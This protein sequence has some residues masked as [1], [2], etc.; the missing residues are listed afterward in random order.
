MGV[1]STGFGPA[2]VAIDV[3]LPRQLGNGTIWTPALNVGPVPA[4]I[5]GGLA[6][7]G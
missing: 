3:D 5:T 7:S 2:L 1:V 6:A 4:L